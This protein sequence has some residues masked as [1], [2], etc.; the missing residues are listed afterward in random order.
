MSYI[1]KY[2]ENDFTLLRSVI[3]KLPP[4]HRE[5]LGVLSRHLSLVASHSD[6]NGMTVKALASQF[7]YAVFRGNT[8][9]QGYVYLKVCY[10]FFLFSLL[11]LLRTRSWKIS[12]Q[13]RIRYL[14]S[15]FLRPH[16]PRPLRGR[17]TLSSVIARCLLPVCRTTRHRPRGLHV[18]TILFVH[19]SIGHFYG[20]LQTTQ[21][22]S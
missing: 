14:T 6:Q 4:A 11:I 15:H 7:C 22:T 17:E 12:F 3:C 19:I 20:P 13:M 10:I 21:A 9:V 2:T 5:T 18:C 16:N 8:I 1:A